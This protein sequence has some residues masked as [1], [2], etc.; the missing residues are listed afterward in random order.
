MKKRMINQKKMN[1]Q[2]R[3]I[4]N[5]SINKQTGCWIWEQKK[6]INGYGCISVNNKT[7]F[8]HRISA[9]V[10]KNF[11]INSNLFVLHKCDNHECINPEHLFIGTQKDNIQDMIQKG[12]C[13]NRKGE[14]NNRAKLLKEDIL[15]IRKLYKNN[16]YSQHKL[17]KRFNITQQHISRII[18]NK[19]WSWLK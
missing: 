18:T 17:A 4:Q 2:Q 1:L 16:I 11:D 8:A 7:Y 14:L 5:S 9:V 13:S 12:R 6:R 10:F 15:L 19:T 3:L